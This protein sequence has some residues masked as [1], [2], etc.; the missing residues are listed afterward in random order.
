MQTDRVI[1]HCDCNS[2]FASV[3]LLDYPQY[4]DKPVAVCGNPEERH[5]IILAKNETAKKYNIQTA[6][7]V[8]Q[9][10]RKCPQLILLRPH[11]KKYAYYSKIINQIYSQYTDRVEAFSVDESWLDVTG[12][13]RLFA[14]SPKELADMLRCRV[15]AETGITISVGVSFNKVFAKLGSDYKKP[16]ATT[17]IMPP[18][19]ESIVYP[20]KVENLLFVGKNA[21]ETLN[22]VGV[23]TIGDLAAQSE[24]ALK[25]MLGK[26]GVM[27]GRYARGEDT[28]PVAAI[29]EKRPIKSIGKGLTFKRDL[30]GIADINTAATA[31]ADSVAAKLRANGLWANCVQ[32]T[33][34]DK[35][36]KSFTRQKHLETPTNLGKTIK[37]EA[38]TLV[39]QNWNIT[40]GIRMLTVTVKNL[41]PDAGAYQ[42]SFLQPEKDEN[43][44]KQQKL[45]QAMDKIREK[46][47]KNIIKQG[48]ILNNGIG[49]EYMDDEQV[50]EDV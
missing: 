47:G 33:I 34:K 1:L 42:L 13:W 31:L 50:G 32:I 16:D 9:A 6:E 22:A 28:E 21:K 4:K 26:T 20:M 8:W 48:S 12:T 18:Q 29:G 46:Y 38:V 15:K 25:A 30:L 19:M 5:G 2:Y 49:I 24:T 35:N 10:L 27:L 14:K 37:T 36:L 45:E 11:H 39:K 44:E 17:V 43:E 41:Q 3:E 23:Y 40:N 7:T